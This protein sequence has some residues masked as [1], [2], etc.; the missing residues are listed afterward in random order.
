MSQLARLVFLLAF[1]QRGPEDVTDLSPMT[2]IPWT[3]IT[4]LCGN[5]LSSSVLYALS[6]YAMKLDERRAAS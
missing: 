6:N 5:A 2:W 1:R 4:W 3:L